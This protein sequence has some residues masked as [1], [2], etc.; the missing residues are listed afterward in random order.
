MAC[1]E[2]KMDFQEGEGGGHLW[3]LLVSK[4]PL[5][6]G[7]KIKKMLNIICAFW[8]DKT[9]FGGGGGIMA[10]FGIKITLNYQPFF[11]MLIIIGAFWEEKK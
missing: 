1:F 5:I 2:K 11:L 3:H 4:S 6:I 9:T 10:P 8:E 7:K